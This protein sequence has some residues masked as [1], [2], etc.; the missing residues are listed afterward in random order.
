MTAMQVLVLNASSLH[1]G[2]LGCYGNG[3]IA[4]PNLDRFA[5]ESVVFD[6]HYACDLSCEGYSLVDVIRSPLDH[7]I[8]IAAS[9]AQKS[10]TQ[11]TNALTQ[12][13]RRRNGLCWL[14]LPSLYPP[15]RIA[16]GFAL[17]YFRGE[18]DEDGQDPVPLELLTD[19]PIGPIDTKD[20]TLWQ[21]IRGTYAGAVTSL[22][23]D[24]GALLD[25]LKEEAIFDELQIVFTTDRGMALGEHGVVGDARPWL[26]EEVTHLPLIVRQPH[27]LDAGRR[28]GALTQPTDLVAT[29]L[30][31][32]GV[33][34]QLDVGTSWLPLQRGEVDRLHE[35]CVSTWRTGDEEE[36]AL[37]MLDSR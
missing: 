11:V 8:R 34:K 7:F 3:W 27:G 21:R 16:E 26:H 9:S 37:R 25:A 19:P 33:A 14:D 24:L 17:D 15:W 32:L 2:F 6:Q 4:T 28:I 20:A 12:L 23:D 30:D 5:A 1:L 31:Q 29:L 18:S 22:D 36:H 35:H 10:I 13:S